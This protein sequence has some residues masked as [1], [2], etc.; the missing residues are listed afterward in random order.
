MVLKSVESQNIEFK[1]SWRDEYLRVISAFANTEFKR[2]CL[3]KPEFKEFFGGFMI[4]F[5]KDIYNEEYLRGLGLNKRQIEA[6]KYVKEK[7]KITN[8]EYQE[9]CNTSERT[10]TRDLSSLVSRGIFK[11]IGTTGRGTEYVLRR[12]KDAKDARKTPERR[13]KHTKN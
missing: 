9:I 2:L 13:Q 3:P 4:E 5:Y 7:G 6:V 12:Q 8:R 10:A 11:Q 1:S